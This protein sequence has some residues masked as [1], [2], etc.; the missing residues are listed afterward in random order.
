V[1]LWPLPVVARVPRLPRG[2]RPNPRADARAREAFRTVRRQL[3]LPGNRRGGVLMASPSRGDGKTTS[4]VL[5][6]LVL[7][8]R[9]EVMLVDADTHKPDLGRVLGVPQ[10]RTPVPVGPKPESRSPSQPVPGLDSL[11]LLELDD[12]DGELDTPHVANLLE[13]AAAQAD[14]VVIDTPP[15]GQVSD[16][17]PLLGGSD[18]VLVVVRL[19]NTKRSEASTA[20]ELIGR[21]GVT[22]AGFIVMGAPTP[23]RSYPYGR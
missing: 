19:G 1:Q 12:V 8:E 18:A 4:T 10:V 6:G 7:A 3:E 14:Y 21:S 9:S 16:A 23:A 2:F 20:R 11:R 17:L 15:L 5:L 22:P 13:S